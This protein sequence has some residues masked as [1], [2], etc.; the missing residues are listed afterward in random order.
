M[1]VGK[2]LIIVYAKYFVLDNVLRE[3]A[4][5]G[6]VYWVSTLKK[7]IMHGRQ[8]TAPTLR[9]ENSVGEYFDVRSIEERYYFKMTSNLIS[10][11]TQA[12]MPVATSLA[13]PAP[14]AVTAPEN[15]GIDFALGD[16]PVVEHSAFK[17]ST[18]Q[19]GT[20]PD[21]NSD[22][23][24]RPRLIQSYTWS[25]SAT[26]LAFYPWT[27]Y[28]NSLEVSN[29]YQYMNLFKGDLVLR[30]VINGMPF[31]YGLD[32]AA[33]F[34]L[35]PFNDGDTNSLTH[36]Q[37][38]FTRHH[39][40]LD[41]SSVNA[42]DLRLPFILQQPFLGIAGQDANGFKDMGYLVVRSLSTLQST[43]LATPT[44]LTVSIY[45]WLE[46]SEFG[47]PTPVQYTPSGPRT[48][49][50]LWQ[51]VETVA[52]SS[53]E[54]GRGPISSIASSVAT[55]AGALQG[56]PIIGEFATAATVVAKAASN[57]FSFLGFSRPPVVDPPIYVRPM[58][59]GSL[60]N[61]IAADTTQSLTLDPRQAMSVSGATFGFSAA[62][63]MCYQY[64]ASRWGLINSTT[65]TQA[66]TAGTVLYTLPV[67]PCV[68]YGFATTGPWIPT[69]LAYLT[70]AHEQW[71]GTIEVRIKVV[72]NKYHSGRLLFRYT[73]YVSGTPTIA[74][75]TTATADACVLDLANENEIILEI[76]WSQDVM[77]LPTRLGFTY[78]N[79]TYYSNQVANGY[80]EVIALS[81]LQAPL[82]T[83]S[84]DLQFFVRGG[85]D[86]QALIPTCVGAVNG[87]TPSGPTDL[88]RSVVAPP[89]VC[90]LT[91][92]VKRDFNP[93][94]VII[95]ETAPSVRALIKRYTISTFVSPF[96]ATTP[97]TGTT[98]A[99]STYLDMR[100]PD[101]LRVVTGVKHF[102]NYLE[103]F[104]KCYL[105]ARGS[106]RYKVFSMSAGTTSHTDILFTAARSF[107]VADL[108]GVVAVTSA[109]TLEAT[110]PTDSGSGLA[111]VL[112]TQGALEFTMPDFGQYLFRPAWWNL[113]G[114][115][116]PWFTNF[117][118]SAI[119]R[120]Y[121]RIGTYA[122]DAP[123]L[124]VA[125]A[126]G[127]DYS[128]FWFQGCPVMT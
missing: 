110:M 87:Y 54:T 97:V 66:T 100:P 103:Y 59:N 108:T 35:Y 71:T 62:D 57:F 26:S 112:P 106:M 76:P 105:G 67:D 9:V 111:M 101:P 4:L 21:V 50:K 10:S 104:S 42:Q 51:S 126:A 89:R 64:I 6:D 38:M 115:S 43:S 116:P 7:P 77:A 60:A 61:V 12:P 63:E 69:P 95:G 118:G 81:A 45:A 96:N 72:C 102:A 92:G 78:P 19:G 17:H 13:V 114:S 18:E 88:G 34:P 98:Y 94:S 70:A 5:A 37:Q 75:Y 15:V 36:V 121:L 125:V 86:F 53:D 20:V 31:N 2:L 117:M 91:L 32:L 27:A 119:I 122:T 113:S 120:W 84:V 11:N 99:T 68:S 46:A 49:S 74:A 90:K 93:T 79:A 30:F 22:Y 58:F 48:R 52:A 109:A 123:F 55:A 39:V 44:A 1:L 28:F 107:G 73:P 83:A 124:N 14:V 85:R 25:G 33:Y 65:W 16:A 47:G 3:T 128:L 29:R 56:V 82:A 23:F 8:P 24:S 41:P 127:E 40:L 80:L